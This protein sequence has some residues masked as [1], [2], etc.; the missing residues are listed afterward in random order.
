MSLDIND[1]FDWQRK[2]DALNG[3]LRGMSR[4][5]PTSGGSPAPAS[6]PIKDDPDAIAIEAEDGGELFEG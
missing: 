3:L 5:A 1:P 2:M 6:D 4:I